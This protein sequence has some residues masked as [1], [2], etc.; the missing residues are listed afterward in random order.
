MV[1]RRIRYINPHGKIPAPGG[2][3]ELLEEIKIPLLSDLQSAQ[4]PA[5][6]PAAF[7]EPPVVAAV[8]SAPVTSS[9]KSR[10]NGKD[11]PDKPPASTAVIAD[12]K[13]T[14][15]LDQS[16]PQEGLSFPESD[17]REA[18]AGHSGV[19]LTFE[20]MEALQTARADSREKTAN[21]LRQL[22]ESV[23]SGD[24]PW[25]LLHAD[26]D[27]KADLG[28]RSG[29]ARQLHGSRKIGL[30]HTDQSEHFAEMVV[31]LAQGIVR[32]NALVACPGW[33][34]WMLIFLAAT[35][36]ALIAEQG[37]LN[38]GLF[39]HFLDSKAWVFIKLALIFPAALAA[40]RGSFYS[41]FRDSKAKPV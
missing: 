32:G 6:R 29:S 38:A 23:A 3:K 5:V 26:Y 2:G 16:D 41:L 1:D 18:V 36:L 30:R 40:L 13:E 11:A 22:A 7:E 25:E 35:C 17:E 10:S 19:V 37:L 21:I 4:L 31:P 28:E 33:F 8:K 20:R 34:L 24:M 14:P 27:G 15:R 12:Q 9:E 39:T